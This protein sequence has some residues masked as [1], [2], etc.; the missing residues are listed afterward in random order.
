MSV[1]PNLGAGDKETKSASHPF[2]YRSAIMIMAAARIV[3]FL[4]GLSVSSS[5]VCEQDGG[6]EGTFIGQRSGVTSVL[7][8]EVQYVY[9]IVYGY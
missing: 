4:A 9:E 3:V 5:L 6:C 1:C 8:C 7:D 2:Q